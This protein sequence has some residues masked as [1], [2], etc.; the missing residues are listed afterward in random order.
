M[1]L[2]HHKALS[3]SLSV[4]LMLFNPW[5]PSIPFFVQQSSL[6]VSPCQ[7]VGLPLHL[8][9]S[10]LYWPS[11]GLSTPAKANNRG[12]TML[13]FP[14]S[15]RSS[16][17]DGEGNNVDIIFPLIDMLLVPIPNLESRSSCGQFS[18]YIIWLALGF[19]L[20]GSICMQAFKNIYWTIQG[21][22]LTI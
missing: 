4:F 21:G 3:Q 15:S 22:F 19:E 9:R 8:Q 12:F 16:L 20:H 2:H 13:L 10:L 1:V 18:F 14:S 11:E 6:T 5:L 17:I 7:G